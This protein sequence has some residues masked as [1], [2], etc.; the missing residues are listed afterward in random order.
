V[1]GG[2]QGPGMRVKRLLFLSSRFLTLFLDN[3]ISAAAVARFVHYTVSHEHLKEF[4]IDRE[5]N[6]FS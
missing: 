6:Y 2:L 5:F 4:H 3:S 1:I